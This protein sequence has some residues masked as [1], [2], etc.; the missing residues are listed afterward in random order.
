MST[1]SNV[2]KRWRNNRDIR[3]L[4]AYSVITKAFFVEFPV[5]T[6]QKEIF[7]RDLWQKRHY[8]HINAPFFHANNVA[9][10]STN[11]IFPSCISSSQSVQI[12]KEKKFLAI[13]Y[14]KVGDIFLSE[15]R[16]AFVILC[17]VIL[18]FMNGIKGD[19]C[20][21]RAEYVYIGTLR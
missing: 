18:F 2:A 14:D 13:Y 21:K 19:L 7:Q 1:L 17:L 12:R 5:R 3:F 4:T 16:S 20:T 9:F 10:C 11:C 6:S 15:S 8:P